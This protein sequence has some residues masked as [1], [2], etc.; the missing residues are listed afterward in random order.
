VNNASA[1]LRIN[2]TLTLNSGGTLNNSGTLS[3]AAFVDNGGTI[4]GAEPV[5]VATILGMFRIEQIQ[6]SDPAGPNPLEAGRAGTG[7]RNLILK[8]H[9]GAGQQFHLESTS[10]LRTWTELPAMV[11]EVNPG[12]FQVTVP[13][14]GGIRFYRLRRL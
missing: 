12:S 13:A 6:L 2:A 11:T 10:D 5:V 3:V 1:T 9:A 7:N 14:Q 8:W 4:I